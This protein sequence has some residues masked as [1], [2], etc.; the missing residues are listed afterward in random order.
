MSRPTVIACS[1]AP[2]IRG[3]F[4][5]THVYGTHVPVEEPSTASEADIAG[6]HRLVWFFPSGEEITLPLGCFYRGTGGSETGCGD[7]IRQAAVTTAHH[8]DRRRVRDCPCKPDLECRRRAGYGRS[9]Q[10]TGQRYLPRQQRGAA[11]TRS[12]PERRQFLRRFMLH[13]LP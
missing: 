4:N 5:S 7:N 9:R 12:R 11:G 8:C 2:P 6:P 1:L 13:W 10:S 3:S